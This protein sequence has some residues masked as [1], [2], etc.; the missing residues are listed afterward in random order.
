MYVLVQITASKQQQLRCKLL[1]EKINL[2]QSKAPLE[3]CQPLATCSYGGSLCR[4]TTRVLPCTQRLWYT[5][6]WARELHVHVH[7]HVQ[8]KFSSWA[9]NNDTNPALN[10]RQ[11]V[12]CV[13][14]TQNSAEKG[15][16]PFFF[17]FVEREDTRIS[18][19]SRDAYPNCTRTHD[20]CIYAHIDIF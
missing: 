20:S 9:S 10:P 12:L 15:S 8:E 13:I 7:V 14:M 17:L 1:I 6:N 19:V 3:P 2:N 5:T 16:N 18:I 11:I 4:C